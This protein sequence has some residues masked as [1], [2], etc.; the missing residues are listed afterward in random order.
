MGIV[1]YILFYGIDL[2]LSSNITL[3]ITIV[4][5]SLIYV[6]LILLFAPGSDFLIT[7]SMGTIKKAVDNIA[8]NN[9][10]I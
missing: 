6:I 5:S 3:I 10:I 9:A 4:V 1:S 2:G 7:L 8:S